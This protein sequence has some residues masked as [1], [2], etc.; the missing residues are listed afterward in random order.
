MKTSFTK[1]VTI[2][3][4]CGWFGL[5]RQSHYQNNNL[6]VAVSKTEDL[7]LTEVSKIRKKHPRMGTRKLYEKLQPIKQEHGIKIGRDALF[8]LLQIN[9]L[10][11]RKR[12]RK[13]YTT[14]S[15][16][17]LRKYPNLIKDF[18]PIQRNQLWVSDI[19]YWRVADNFIY[20]SLITDVFSHKIVGYH[21]AETLESS[22]TIQALKMALTGFLNEPKS[23]FKLVHHSDR[24]V[25]Y[26]QHQYV[27]LLKDNDIQISM[28][29]SGDPLENAVAE[30]ING[31]LKDE[32]LIDSKPENF[33]QAKIKLIESVNAYNTD[34]PHMS[35]G[36]NYPQDVHEKNIKTRKLWKSYYKKKLHL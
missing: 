10:L 7:I 31:I 28:T 17:W 15:F 22:E 32:Y 34:R 25:Q 27:K 12:K 9:N 24:G 4:L 33:E 11:C 16:H 14:Q 13:V 18:V 21:V 30:R 3:K 2:S 5:S 29:Q 35:I 20:I 23:H 36:N 1:K 6:A 8:T 19:T 26:C